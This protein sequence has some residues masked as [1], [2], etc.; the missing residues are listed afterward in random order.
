MGKTD[1][2]QRVRE[3]RERMGYTQESLAH[4]AG[5]SSGTIARIE[6]GKHD[7]Q[8]ATLIRVARALKCPVAEL[9][10]EA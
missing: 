9:R 5:V 7:A 1:V 8:G 4:V 2:G 10:G 6:R 3:K